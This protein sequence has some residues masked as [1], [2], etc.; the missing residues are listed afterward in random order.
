MS[1]PPSEPPAQPP[2]GQPDQQPPA[3][4]Q[5][6]PSYGQPG[7]QPPPAGSY[8]PP[9][10]GGYAPPQPTGP[11]GLDSIKAGWECFKAS[12]TPFVL[13]TLIW[14]VII[15][16]VTVIPTVILSAVVAATDPYDPYGPGY[17]AMGG[18]SVGMVVVVLLALAG[19]VVYMG[20]FASASLKAIDGHQVTVGD[21]FKIKNFGQLALLALIIGVAG[22]VLYIT[23]IGTMAIAF[24]GAFAV[25]FV[26]DRNLSAIDA[27]KASIQL[28]L[29][30][31]GQTI[32]VL[33]LCYLLGMAG[34]LACGVGILVTAPIA[35]LA[36]A[37]F[38]RVLTGPSAGQAPPAPQFG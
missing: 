21:F 20:A 27:V 23:V 9:A 25:Y 38:Y 37:H 34:S 16:A 11:Q 26:V 36:I 2:Y 32:I 18:F 5:T 6:P 1:Q 22:A 17:V 8:A 10:A 3:Q 31:A 13:G 12:A 15:G 28:A 30:N 33:L 29:A 7:Q 14:G 24:F 4:P 35:Q 19:A